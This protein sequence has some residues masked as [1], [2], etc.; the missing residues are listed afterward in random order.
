VPTERVAALRAAFDAAIKDPD[1]IKAAAAARLDVS[2][3]AGTVLQ[4]TVRNV[5][6]TPAAL[7]ARARAIIA[8]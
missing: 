4:V 5:L 1:L 2:P 6:A 3:I 7:V 8:E